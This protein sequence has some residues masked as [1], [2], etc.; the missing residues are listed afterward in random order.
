MDE[1]TT[2]DA[3][4]VGQNVA[5]FR[6]RAPQ[7]DRPGEFALKQYPSVARTPIVASIHTNVH[8]CSS[9]AEEGVK[10]PKR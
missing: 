1:G 3:D 10:C 8:K 2:K 7:K 6:V 4:V 5:D 9:G